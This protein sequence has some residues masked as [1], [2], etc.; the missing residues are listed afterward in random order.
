[1]QRWKQV[2]LFFICLGAS[3]TTHAQLFFL[4]SDAFQVKSFV[5]PD[6]STRLMAKKNRLISTLTYGY[7]SENKEAESLRRRTE[8]NSEGYP[9]TYYEF[10]TSGSVESKKEYTYDASRTKILSAV[11]ERYR[12][13]GDVQNLLGYKFDESGRLLEY[14]EMFVQGLVRKMV[15][16]YNDNGKLL[17]LQHIEPDGLPGGAEVYTY[18][19]KGTEISMDRTDIAG[20]LVDRVTWTLDTRGRIIGENR[21][22]GGEAP[23]LLFSYKYKYDEKGRLLRKEKYSRDLVL[24]GW[25]T[26]TFDGYGRLLEHKI[27]ETG[28]ENPTRE[29]NKYDRYGRVIEAITYNGDGSTFQWYKYS[30]DSLA[31]GAGMVRLLP[32]G[33]TDYSKIEV[34]NKNRQILS[35]D[36][37]YSD[38]SGDSKVIYRYSD[39]G[40]LLDEKHLSFGVETSVFWY[41]HEKY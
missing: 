22:S 19:P 1:M 23:I 21:Y 28:E 26:N 37:F 10:S 6:A 17:R 18:D 38:G 35:Q 14:S 24:S 34:F 36:E 7:L 41:V 8:Y 3:A 40:L 30:F 13:N 32:D 2:C 12:S 39:D 20:D 9:V 16:T 25:E 15:Y 11:I 33:K 4:E 29:V 27:L 31:T 5:P